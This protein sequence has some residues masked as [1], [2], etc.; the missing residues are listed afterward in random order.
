M[1][2]KTAAPF[3]CHPPKFAPPGPPEGTSWSCDNCHTEYHAVPVDTQFGAEFFERCVEKGWRTFWSTNPSL[4]QQRLPER[5]RDMA[6]Q[7]DL[8][9]QLH[10]LMLTEAPMVC[11]RESGLLVTDSVPLS[12]C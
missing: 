9:D 4:S 1:T 6:E 5:D 8:T 12:S 3:C 2:T 7:A 10:H 11:E